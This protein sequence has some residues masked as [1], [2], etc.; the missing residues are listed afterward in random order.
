LGSFNRA[1]GTQSA[2]FPFTFSYPSRGDFLAFVSDFGG[3]KLMHESV[4]IFR[5]AAQF[6]A[7]GGTFPS[8]FPGMPST[9]SASFSSEGYP[10]VLVTDT[11]TLRNDMH[12]GPS[13]THDRLDYDRM[14]RAT[15]GLSRVVSSLANSTGQLN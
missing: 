7:E 13:D 1:E 11:G 9:D 10:A 5:T 15:F 14:A 8:W 4:Q 12:G 2:P 3:R 6:P